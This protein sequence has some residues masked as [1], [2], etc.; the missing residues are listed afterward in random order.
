MNYELQ[1][2]KMVYIP[3]CAA[4]VLSVRDNFFT[5]FLNLTIC[6][7]ANRSANYCPSCHQ[8]RRARLDVNILA[9]VFR[10]VV[11]LCHTLPKIA[12]YTYIVIYADRLKV[13]IRCRVVGLFPFV[14]F[15]RSRVSAY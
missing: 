6:T 9:G 13:P 5:R 4:G 2:R 12:A 15:S 8:E 3:Q 11:V 10:V 1:K 7:P 14:P